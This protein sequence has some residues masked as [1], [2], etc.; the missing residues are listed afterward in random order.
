[1]LTYTA[2]M[3]LST[4]IDN[5]GPWPLRPELSNVVRTGGPA[6]HVLDPY[7]GYLPHVA[8][9]REGRLTA[10]MRLLFYSL[11]LTPDVPYLRARLDNQ[12][13]DFGNDW[14]RVGGVGEDVA[15]PVWDTD[16]KPTPQFEAA[17]RLI[18]ERGWTLQQH[19]GGLEDEMRMGLLGNR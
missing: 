4:H 13:M 1:M 15:R 19:T 9:E 18:A 10:R 5:G 14:L 11:D 6:A 2:S 8:L 17:L 16:G 7:A 12:M 3:S